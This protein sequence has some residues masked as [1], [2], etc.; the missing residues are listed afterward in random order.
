MRWTR[1]RARQGLLGAGLLLLSGALLL[2]LVDRQLQLTV[3]TPEK[4]FAIP[5]QEQDGQLYVNVMDLL[6]PLGSVSLKQK[7]KE[8][9]LTF[10][11]AEAVFTEGSEN[12]KLHG[13][14]VNFGG[15]AVAANNAL[16]VPVRASF[17]IISALLKVPVELH[18]DGRRLFLQNT[19]THFT[20]E[21]KKSDHPSLLLN[22]DHPVN[23]VVTQ[24]ETKIKF[25]F[26]REPVVSDIS[27]QPLE[28]K[29]I[30]SLAFSEENGLASLT[31][32]GSSGLSASVAAD[33]RS[34]VIQTPA[35]PPPQAPAV[36]AAPAPEPA[37]PAQAP[38]P[39]V[40]FGNQT[41]SGP[42]FFV[43][44]D[45]SH[46]GDDQGARLGG[47]LAEKD[48]TL[49]LAR[50]I[51][52]EL[53][54]RGVAVRLLRDSDVTISLEQRAEISNEQR[55]GAYLA[56]HAGIP[57]GGVRVYTPAFGSNDKA[58][59]GRFLSWDN[60]QEAYVPRSRTLA[61]GIA[62]ELDKRDI[63]ATT[64]GTQL[65]PLN[66]INA[67]AIAIELAAD[68]DN[69]QDITDQKFQNTVA[70]AIAVSIAQLRGQLEGQQ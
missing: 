5:V 3:Y 27:N 21:L 25:T 17:P 20:A 9:K 48:V 4:S 19:A 61:K 23:P 42:A 8:W 15:K 6:S 16:L 41:H 10:N 63:T 49:A 14:S 38:A 1:S 22:F 68:P 30:H 33:G 24:D 62:G 56:I 50:K 7:N 12:A 45:A 64:L 55:A 58:A 60:A 52:N 11:G 18:V 66:N 34:I 44:I 37:A 47:R 39:P 69:V 40:F 59:A 35:P 13:K 26:R 29:S 36:A 70:A 46:G 43:M 32:N 53:Q 67:P 2:G 54:E 51:K 57:G 31:I 28:D 65:R